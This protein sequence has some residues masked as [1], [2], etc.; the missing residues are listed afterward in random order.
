MSVTVIGIDP[1]LTATGLARLTLGQPRVILGHPGWTVQ[2][3]V[4]RSHG[5]RDDGWLDRGIRI[6]SISED[7][8][9]WA[10]PCDLAVI[11]GPS[12]GSAV[13]ASLWDRAGLWWRIAAR[14]LSSCRVA[15]V[16]PASR[17]RWATGHGRA[18][19]P[20]VVA[21]VTG[22]WRPWWTPT[23]P[24]VDDQA[25][26]LVLASMGAQWL[27]VLPVP[28]GDPAAL[29]GARWPVHETDYLDHESAR[30]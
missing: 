21:A 15:V 5:H 11:E 27:G 29:A 28:G 1:S 26:A 6:A 8:L 22:M 18:D 4:R 30:P 14:L 16:P 25:D 17:A 12:H 10:L 20:V 23:G 3:S 24:C 13:S 9:A 7:V 19:K 2:T